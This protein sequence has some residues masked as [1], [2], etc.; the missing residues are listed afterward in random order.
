MKKVLKSISKGTSK[1]K[2]VY[3][4]QAM[5]KEFQKQILCVNVSGLL[6]RKKIFACGLVFQLRKNV[7]TQGARALQ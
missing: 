2:V 5:E 3:K 1:K 7:S 6:P 4:R